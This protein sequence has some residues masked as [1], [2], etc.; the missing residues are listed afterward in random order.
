MTAKRTLRN[1]AL[2][3][4]GFGSV[5]QCPWVLAPA[6]ITLRVLYLRR[7]SRHWIVDRWPRR[8]RQGRGCADFMDPLIK[9]KVSR[10]SL[11]SLT[12]RRYSINIDLNL[13]LLFHRSFGRQSAVSC[14]CACDTKGH[15]RCDC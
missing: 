4:H 1:S 2:M 12:T 10:Q 7:V 14:F 5:S 3:C 15:G 6:D 8:W 11:M 9:E 13:F